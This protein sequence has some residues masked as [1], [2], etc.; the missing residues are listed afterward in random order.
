VSTVPLTIIAATT[1]HLE[2]IA[3]LEKASF[4]S[5]WKRDFFAS[6][7]SAPGRYNR[8]A[9]DEE[10]DE[11]VAYLFAMFL[12]DEMHINKIAVLASLRRQGVAALLMGECFDFAEAH[13]VQSIS[14][15]VR[16][17]NVGAVGFYRRLQFSPVY[18]RRNY[19]PDGEA[20]L[21]MTRVL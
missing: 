1:A 3:A 18:R 7:I 8:V 21:V 17:S 20:A 11:L 2:A 4:P 13:A 5:P 9:W 16:E 19:Y 12:F 14:L 10:R 15:E 6:E